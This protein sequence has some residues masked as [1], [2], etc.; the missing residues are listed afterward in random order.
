MVIMKRMAPRKKLGIDV[1]A[2][3]KASVLKAQRRQD[4]DGMEFASRSVGDPNDDAVLRAVM[5]VTLFVPGA[6]GPGYVDD[7]VTRTLPSQRPMIFRDSE[8]EMRDRVGVLETAVDNAL[9]YDSPPKCAKM[10]QDVGFCTHLGRLCRPCLVTHLHARSL[11]RSSFIL[12]VG[13][14]PAKPPPQGNRLRLSAAES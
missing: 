1:M 4:G 9:D 14:V 8:V 12:G 13:M 2:Q 7:E 5:S 6:D 3:L 10:L 11:R